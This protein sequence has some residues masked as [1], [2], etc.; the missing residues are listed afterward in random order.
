ME[1]QPGDGL[2]ACA[3][4]VGQQASA[5]LGQ[6]QQDGRGFEYGDTGRVIDQHRNATV[7]MQLQEIGLAVLTFVDAHVVQYVWDAELF[8][9]DGDLETI[10]RAVGVQ[11]QGSWGHS[12]LLVGRLGAEGVHVTA[13]RRDGSACRLRV[14]NRVHAMQLD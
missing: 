2:P 14:G 8:Q 10:G 12:G 9:R 5:L 3:W 1:H 11:V 4:R 13:P 7:R 6:V